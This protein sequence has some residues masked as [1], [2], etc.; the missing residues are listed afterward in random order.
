MYQ[1]FILALLYN[2]AQ[3]HFSTG[4]TVDLTF[5][6]PKTVTLVRRAAAEHHHRLPHPSLSFLFLYPTS[7]HIDKATQLNFDPAPP[8]S[9]PA[10]PSFQHAHIRSCVPQLVYLRRNRVLF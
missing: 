7:A 8:P 10:R 2:N 1:Y 9:R 6:A 3:A 4:S 5:D